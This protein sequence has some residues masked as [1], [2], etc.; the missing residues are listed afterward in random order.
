MQLGKIQVWVAF[1]GIVVATVSPAMANGGTIQGKVV[2]AANGSPIDGAT[3][4]VLG[5]PQGTVSAS[6]GSF[7]LANIQDGEYTLHV[8]YLGYVEA[9]LAGVVVADGYASTVEISLE[10]SGEVMDEVVITTARSRGS[11]LAL[12]V[13]RHQSNLTVEKIGA[14]ELARKGVGDAAG[15]VA[16]LSGISRQEGT[17]Q[18]Y[19]RGLGDRYNSTSLNGLPLPSNDPE[20]KNI[21]LDWFSTDMV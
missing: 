18:I 12:L 19:V 5:T 15:A 21:A 6:D 10:E 2:D 7:L 1:V 17:K 14:Q 20:R 8:S 4:S 11:D 16:K 3:V 9:R 13:E